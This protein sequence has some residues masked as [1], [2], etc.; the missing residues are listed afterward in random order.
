MYFCGS[1]PETIHRWQLWK[2]WDL[3]M[4]TPWADPEIVLLQTDQREPPA[5]GSSVLNRTL[6]DSWHLA[7]VTIS[8]KYPLNIY[9]L[10]RV[11]VRDSMRLAC[12]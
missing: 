6:N 7:G 1:L 4:K 11:S 5:V 9:H 10:E 3:T 2:M 12:G 8:F